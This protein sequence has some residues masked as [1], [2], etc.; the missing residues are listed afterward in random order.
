MKK[1]AAAKLQ[2]KNLGTSILLLE[3]M[4]T[5]TTVPFPNIAHKNTIQ[6]P[7]RSVHQSKRSWHGKKGPGKGRQWIFPGGASL[8]VILKASSS[9]Y[10]S[11]YEG[12]LPGYVKSERILSQMAWNFFPN[13]W[14]MFSIKLIMK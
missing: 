3:K 5:N 9:P 4:R 8:L 12:K 14:L 6:T 1:S 7:H 10:S 13:L 11:M 2:T